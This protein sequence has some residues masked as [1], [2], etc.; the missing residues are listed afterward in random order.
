MTWEIGTGRRRVITLSD[1]I[2]VI[3]ND[4]NGNPV[5]KWTNILPAGC[6]FIEMDYPHITIEEAPLMIEEAKP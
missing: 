1:E 5:F 3:K 2:V 4:E 6:M